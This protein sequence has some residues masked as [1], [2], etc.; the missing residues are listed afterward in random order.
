MQPNNSSKASRSS[1]TSATLPEVLEAYR[2][3]KT[4]ATLPRALQKLLQQAGAVPVRQLT[5]TYIRSVI[6]APG[7]DPILRRLYALIIRYFL[8][9]SR[10]NGHLPAGRPVVNW[11]ELMATGSHQHPARPAPISNPASASA[12]L[13]D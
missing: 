11:R 6:R 3:T 9:W 1:Q 2:H 4:T 10:S 12:T 8:H 13:K 7:L 5:A